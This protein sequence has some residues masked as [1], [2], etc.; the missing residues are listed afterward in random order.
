MKKIV[1]AIL[2]LLTPLVVWGT[3]ENLF[4][5]LHPEATCHDLM[6]VLLCEGRYIQGANLTEKP[7]QQISSLYYLML[8]GMGTGFVYANSMAYPSHYFELVCVRYGSKKKYIRQTALH[9]GLNAVWYASAATLV[10]GICVLPFVFRQ[11]AGQAPW[12]IGTAVLVYVGQW[13]KMVLFFHGMSMVG[14]LLRHRFWEMSAAAVLVL[15]SV[16]LTIFD[17]LMKGS[18]I[19]TLTSDWTQI[20]K[21]GAAA[22]LDGGVIWLCQRGIWA[23]E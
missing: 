7:L 21:I 13:L 17:I 3:W 22:L 8:V 23:E 10:Y 1:L 5:D 18:G 4:Q 19:V 9:N 2:I 16:G 14:E 15:F 11:Q 6:R 12:G 20:I